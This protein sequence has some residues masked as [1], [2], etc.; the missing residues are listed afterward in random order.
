VYTF[1]RLAAVLVCALAFGL[2]LIAAPAVA[3]ESAQP[4]VGNPF[5]VPVGDH[6]TVA[7]KQGALSNWSFGTKGGTNLRE[8]VTM[9][10]PDYPGLSI[11]PNN[12]GCSSVTRGVWCEGPVDAGLFYGFATITIDASSPFGYAGE[13]VVSTP[14]GSQVST[15]VWVIDLDKASMEVRATDVRGNVGDTVTVAITVTNPGPSPI[16]GWAIDEVHAPG[17]VVVG[18]HGCSPGT[19]GGSQVA[20]AHPGYVAGGDQTTVSFDLKIVEATSPYPVVGGYSI[21]GAVPLK[22]TD[23]GV[24]FYLFVGPASRG[25]S[26]PGHPGSGGPPATAADPQPSPSDVLPSASAPSNPSGSPSLEVGPATLTSSQRPLP[27]RWFL[28]AGTG[29][30]L[31][32]A[33]FTLGVLRQRR[34]AVVPPATAPTVVPS[35]V[36]PSEIID[37]VAPPSP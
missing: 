20:C 22:R 28:V 2:P 32:V 16:P 6:G 27:S 24:S 25:G 36:D 35:E 8:E 26:A 10:I 14:N 21:M 7:L 29:I 12:P 15:P 23:M 3:A 19:Y 18:Q 4:F 30:A 5:G 9:T 1:R 17:T 31:L 37:Q 11:A 13:V 34:R 33:F